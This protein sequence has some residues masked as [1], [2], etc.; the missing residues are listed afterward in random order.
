[1]A[2]KFFSPN[3]FLVR[4]PNEAV[5]SISLSIE[6]FKI[7]KQVLSKIEPRLVVLIVWY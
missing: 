1:M 5:S 7:K 3:Q 4:N 2:H 6:Y